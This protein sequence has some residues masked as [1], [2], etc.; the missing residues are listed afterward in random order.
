MTLQKKDD[1]SKLVVANLVAT[2]LP[3]ATMP[4]GM[5]WVVNCLLRTSGGR[6]DQET[7]DESRGGGLLKKGK[8]GRR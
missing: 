8:A 1:T 6:R 4:L 5:G 7:R 2:K 3:Y